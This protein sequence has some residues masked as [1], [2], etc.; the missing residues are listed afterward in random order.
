V[1]VLACAVRVENFGDP[2]ILSSDFAWQVGDTTAEDVARELGPPDEIQLTPQGLHFVYRAAQRVENRF[3]IS[4][5]VKLLSLESRESTARTVF[6]SF[7]ADGRLAAVRTI[8]PLESAKLDK[9]R[10]R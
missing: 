8:A 2:R 6:V 9:R 7:D 5:V 10:R 3:L 4:Y 1:V